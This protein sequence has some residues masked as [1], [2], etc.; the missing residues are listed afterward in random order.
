MDYRIY[1]LIALVG[2]GIWGFTSKVLTRNMN[3]TLLIFFATIA[4]II[5]ITI[6]TFSTTSVRI[7]RFAIFAFLVGLVSS[8]ATISFYLALAKG[9]ASVVIPFTGLY[10]I[11]PAILG[12]II[13]KEPLNPFHIVGIILAV[14]AIILFSL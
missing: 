11:I 13:L 6:Y 7:D 4:P 5:F 14:I 1:C 8:I 2:W 3:M 10:F 12:F 9:P